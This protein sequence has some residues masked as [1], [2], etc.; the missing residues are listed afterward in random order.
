LKP[1]RLGEVHLVAAQ[2]LGV[3]HFFSINQFNLRL[4]YGDIKP[5]NLMKVTDGKDTFVV[6][7]IDF[8][9]ASVSQTPD[10][11]NTYVQLRY[12]RSPEVLLGLQ[13]TA[14]IDMGSLSCKLVELY[15]GLPLF[16]CENAADQLRKQ[17]KLFGK[18][19]RSMLRVYGGDDGGGGDELSKVPEVTH[20]ERARSIS[21]LDDE[22]D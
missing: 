5:E 9:L 21:L 10:M 16:A 15:T 4:I 19:L 17:V 12:N 1:I 2:L 20:E 6:K 14:A 7:L 18:P 3:L 22:Q 13:Y 8:S 11:T